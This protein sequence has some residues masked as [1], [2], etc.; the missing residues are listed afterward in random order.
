MNVERDLGRLREYEGELAE[1][2]VRL[3]VAGREVEALRSIVAGLKSRI[4]AA[5][6]DAVVSAPA[7]TARAD[8]I[9]P[10]VSNGGQPRR[11]V[12]SVLRTH[13]EQHGQITTDEAVTFIASLSEFRPDT[14]S[15]NTIVSRLGDLIRDGIAESAGR[16][17]YKL[18]PS[19]AAQQPLG[20]EQEGG[21]M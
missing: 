9:S 11:G 18:R 10:A 14:P 4:A 16:G 8:A 2:E 21:P 19:G 12:K 6:G 17:V 7:A 5:K 3:S 15:R 20:Q 1:A 13:L